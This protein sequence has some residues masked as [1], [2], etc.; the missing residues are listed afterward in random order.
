MQK[1]QSLS[2]NIK[3]VE[4]IEILEGS[5]LGDDYKKNYP[6]GTK[7]TKRNFIRTDIG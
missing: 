2:L 6:K 1:R 3:K 5:S 7:L 4:Q